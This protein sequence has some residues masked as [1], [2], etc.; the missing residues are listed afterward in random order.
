MS[1]SRTSSEA[2]AGSKLRLYANFTEPEAMM[3]ELVIGG[4]RFRRRPWAAAP[5]A[6]PSE[7]WITLLLHVLLIAITANSILRIGESQRAAVLIPLAIGGLILGVV[8]SRTPEL[9]A[10][11]HVAALSIGVF[12]S[13]ALATT[14]TYGVSAT[15]HAHGHQVIE[16]A[17]RL[18]DASRPSSSVRPSDDDLLAIIGLTLWLVGYSSAWL[19]YRRH[20]LAAALIMPASLLIVSLRI[21]DPAPGAPLAA[22][23]IA[24]MIISARHQAFLRQVEWARFRIPAPPALPS[25]FAASGA[26]LALVALLAGLT[27]PFQAPSGVSDWAAN[28]ATDLWDS[29]NRKSNNLSVPGFGQ[30]GDPGA[31]NE[32]SNSF[33]VGE[34]FN[35]SHSVVARVTS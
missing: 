3:A 2:T 11:F 12:A 8:F 15:W 9:D 25:G 7:G 5:D 17:R 24:A 1:A 13:L 28:Q 16:I 22:F 20:W 35:P 30:M 21:E 31:F 4:T 29:V 27:L 26:T 10:Y 18:I 19:L 33:K 6:A 23:A 32:F 34:P 14:R